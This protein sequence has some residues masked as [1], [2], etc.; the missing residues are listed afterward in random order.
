MQVVILFLTK[1]WKYIVLAVLGLY[2]Y[3][4][5][6]SFFNSNHI[7]TT[8]NSVGSTI[9]SE[10]AKA[11]AERLFLSMSDYGTDED[12]INVVRLQLSNAGNLRAV[13]NA[14][15]MRG[16][17]SYGTPMFGSGTPTD[18]KGWLKNELS[19]DAWKIWE[20]MFLTAEI[21]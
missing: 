19:G 3:R 9:S 10:Q 12:S 7:S 8:Y 15:G 16:Y 4:W 14:F 1:Y 11:F 2:I 21:I 20:Q 6:R 17:G 5:V 18:L 13:Y